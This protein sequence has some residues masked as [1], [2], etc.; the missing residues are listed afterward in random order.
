MLVVV[1]A[2][3]AAR[4]PLAR[5]PENT[6]KFAVGVMLSSFGMFWSAEGAGASWPGDDAAL[7]VIVLGVLLVALL[8]IFALRRTA[9]PTAGEPGERD[10]R[11]RRRAGGASTGERAGV[12]CAGG[13]GA[14]SS[15][16]TG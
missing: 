10:A 9:A 4:A 5:V 15:A 2:G 7:P 6:L 3:V 11:G 13:V 14:L 12:R 16:T 1:A 8:L